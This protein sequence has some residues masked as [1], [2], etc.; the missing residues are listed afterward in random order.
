MLNGMSLHRKHLATILSVSS[1]FLVLIIDQIEGCPLGTDLGT[2]K[3]ED[4]KG[5][6]V[7]KGVPKD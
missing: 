5:L 6:D 1:F 7:V 4:G 3:G 2:K